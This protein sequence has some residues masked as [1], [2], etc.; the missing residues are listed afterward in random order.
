MK[1]LWRMKTA[2]CTGRKKDESMDKSGIKYL[3]AGMI[4]LLWMGIFAFLNGNCQSLWA[5]EVASVGFI[6]NGLSLPEVLDTYL[7]VENN[8]P[9]YPLILYVV[10]RIMPYGEK[11]LLIPSILFCLAGIVLLAM[12]VE[13]LKGKRAGFLALCMGT[14]SGILIWQ[15][16]WEVRCYGL[17][18]MLSSLVLYAYIGKSIRPD[19]KR[20][21]LWGTALAFF[22]WTHWFAF[23]LMA[24][25]GIVDLTLVMLRKISWKQLLCYVPGCLLYFPWLI[26][27][28]YYK[29][30]G[31]EDYWSNVP[32]WKNMFWTILFYVSGNRVLW[33]LCLITGAAVMFCAVRRL[34]EPYSEEKTK[35]MLSAFC[36]AAISWMIGLV[37]LFSRYIVPESGLYV[38]RYFT[39]IQPHILLVTALGIDGILDLAGKMG[40][41]K[42]YWIAG[43]GAWAVRAAVAVL[44]V[45]SFMTSYRN[46][47]IAIRKPLEPYREAADYLIKEKG[48]WD[49]TSLFTGSNRFCMLDGF[50]HYYFEKRGYEPP[51][52]IVGSKVLSEQEGRFYKE[53]ADLSEEELLSYDRIYCL[54]IHMSPDEA[55]ERFLKAHYRKVQERDETGIEIWER[56]DNRGRSGR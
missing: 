6:R 4:L 26:M 35:V 25:Y 31:L 15:A 11:F 9:L 12:S 32:Q 27:S 3:I 13:R 37:Y 1:K 24:F 36:V 50:V 48:V 53:Y 18:F 52:N 49:E 14:S 47:Y 30:A 40:K 20:L 23:L 19:R 46:Q 5:D 7:H 8:L 42:N 33:Y 54:R 56:A 21:I 2:G 10:Y 29:H 51:A 45:I 16:A 44:L 22:F 43:A 38:E 17:A 39:V 55:F 28:F 41:Q 34:R